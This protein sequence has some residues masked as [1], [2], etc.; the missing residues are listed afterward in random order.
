MRGRTRT[1]RSGGSASKGPWL[2]HLATGGS[3][4][5]ASLRAMGP[6]TAEPARRFRRGRAGQ[7]AGAQAEPGAAAAS[8]ARL[9]PTAR[10][11]HSDGRAPQTTAVPGRGH[12]AVLIVGDF[13]KVV[14]TLGEDQD[15]AAPVR[16]GGGGYAERLLDQFGGSSIPS[17]PRSV[18]RRVVER[19]AWR[20]SCDSRPRPPPARRNAT[21]RDGLRAGQADLDH[22]VPVPIAAG[23]GLRR[24]RGGCRARRQDQ[25]FNLLVGRDLQRVRQEPQ[26][27]LTTPLLVGTDGVQKMSRPSVTT[28][29][30]RTRRT[31]CSAS[32][33]GAR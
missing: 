30:S 26:V 27:A 10:S 12:T 14:E 29:G 15:I 24:G 23:D 1:R 3:V 33:L 21:T 20:R 18:Q 32:W 19:W 6:R 2:H 4:L 22:G 31:R 8:E 5:L 13:V 11:S 25:T 7:G 28:S 16:G 9:D 17:V